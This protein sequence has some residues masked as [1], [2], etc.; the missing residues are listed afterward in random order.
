MRRGHMAVSAANQSASDPVAETEIVPLIAGITPLIFWSS[1]R[2][3]ALAQPSSVASWSVVVLTD[4]TMPRHHRTA[5][6][7]V[8]TASRNRRTRCRY[9]GNETYPCPA[10]NTINVSCIGRKWVTAGNRYDVFS[11]LYER[12]APMT[13]TIVAR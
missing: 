10:C 2:P 12:T 9:T 7:T 6:A 4:S 13:N 5:M 11:P 3:G 1:D 8:M